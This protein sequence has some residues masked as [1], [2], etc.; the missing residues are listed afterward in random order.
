[1]YEAKSAAYE[2]LYS[3]FGISQYLLI[4][5]ILSEHFSTF[6]EEL[7]TK[8]KTKDFIRMLTKENYYLFMQFEVDCD[9]FAKTKEYYTLCRKLKKSIYYSFWALLN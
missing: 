8:G 6:M 9:D 2:E 4:E 5:S 3:G 7:Q 1:M